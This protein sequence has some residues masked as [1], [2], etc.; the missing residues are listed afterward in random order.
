MI[1]S[2]GEET[3]DYIFNGAGELTEVWQD[4]SVYSYEYDHTGLRTSK[5]VDSE[6]TSMITDGMY[7]VAEYTGI[8]STYYYRG[9]N[10]IGYTSAEETAYYRMNAHGDVVAVV[11]GF[12]E[13]LK[14]YKY[15]AFGGQE[16]DGNEWLWR[17]L[18]V[19]EEDTNPF[20]YC[21]EYYDEETEFIYLRARYYSP[22][23]QRFISEDPIKDGINWYAYCGNN[24]VMFVDLY[25]L[26]RTSWDEAHLTEEELELIDQYTNDWNMAKATFNPEGMKEAH[27]KAEE[28][29]QRYRKFPEIGYSDGN[30]GTIKG[31]YPSVTP[32][33]TSLG[34]YIEDTELKETPDP[35]IVEVNVN[36]GVG[37][38]AK[39]NINGVAVEGGFKATF[40]AIAQQA[41]VMQDFDNSLRTFTAS[42][43]V[44]LC[45]F[46]EAGV[47]YENQY[48]YEDGHSIGDSLMVGIQC[49]GVN[50]GYQGNAKDKNDIVIEIGAG[51]YLLIGADINLKINISRLIDVIQNYFNNPIV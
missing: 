29:R 7:V 6:T 26:Y 45:R 16:E 17:V 47:S 19:Y 44:S 39:A 21:A 43:L 18:G 33:D 27:N 51:A 36:S 37:I 28:I 48:L 34:F 8:Q 3:A 49:N 24:P 2:D 13:T 42:A 22:E 38:Y 46:L 5:T 31:K 40:D 30:T 41:S 14:T 9:M 11:D 20:R 23:I 1:R 25:G 10:L 32:V 12:G 15:D 35:K 50:V 4:N